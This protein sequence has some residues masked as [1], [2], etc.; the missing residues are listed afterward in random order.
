MPV[1][2]SHA[3]RVVYDAILRHP[4]AHNVQ[5]HDVRSMLGEFAHATA[6]PDG[7]MAYTKDGRRL[8]LSPARTKD[9]ESHEQLKELREFLTD[10]N[11]ALTPAVASGINL[12]VVLDHREAR[13]YRTEVRNSIPQ[14]IVPHDPDNA[15]RHLHS[16]TNDA[17]G[18]RNPEIK[19]YYEAI[20]RILSGAEQVLILGSGTGA[21]SALEQLVSHLAQH[22]K[23]IASR[24]IGAVAV[25]EQHM[26]ENQL[27]AKARELYATAIFMPEAG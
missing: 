22:E 3:H 8:V 20:A 10:S 4:S 2:L 6:E 5:W 7:S 26:T 12:L 1:N 9:V 15:G 24:V 23:Q 27:L 21:A 16:V 19:S 18:Q 11:E 25:N 17:N 14:R 13:V